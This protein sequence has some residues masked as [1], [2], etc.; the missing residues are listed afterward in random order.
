MRFAWQEQQ[1]LLR[2]MLERF[3]ADRY[4][5]DAR[6]GR[7]NGFDAEAWREL[8]ELGVLGLPFEEAHGG[9]GGSAL[10]VLVV[11][12]AFG[13]GLAA[14][15]YATSI[16]LGGA[17]LRHAGDETQKAEYIPRLVSGD[18]R[19]CLAYAEPG[20]R[21]DPAF[22]TTTALRVDGGYL[23]N[24]RKVVVL[25]APDAQACFVTA[26]SAGAE[27]QA[28]GL[29][30]LLTPLDAPG[31]SLTPFR[32][33]D[34]ASAADIAFEDVFVPDARLFGPAGEAL[35]LVERALDEATAAVCAEAVG[36]ISALNEKCVEHAKTRRAFGQSLS[37]FQVIQHRLVDM[38]IAYEMA[39]AIALKAASQIAA[40]AAGAARSVSSCK[41]LVGDE[42]G[43]VGKAAVQLHGAIGMTDEL[44]VGHYFKRLMAIRASFGDADFHLRRRIRLAAA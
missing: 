23:L 25:G 35:P 13:R 26:R 15:P 42:A 37:E 22:A 36:I 33:I 18:L 10:D 9:S 17:L 30:L 24:G 40:G 6:R 4:A 3:V 2:S 29:S 19:L 21:F 32:C 14:T 38:Q 41:V 5:F 12:E 28:E 20:S 44:D 27:H 7:P 1:Q 34:G 43:F 8:A 16:V 31:V 39:A 11:M